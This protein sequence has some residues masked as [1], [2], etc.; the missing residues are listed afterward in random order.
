MYPKS[1]SVHV[2]LL[3]EQKE[4]VGRDRLALDSTGLNALADHRL[5][6]YKFSSNG[7]FN[8]QPFMS[9]PIDETGQIVV[10][11]LG[12]CRLT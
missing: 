1:R 12:L 11:R 10:F 2:Q 6:V 4:V 7:D 3:F 9:T 5:Q 8:Q